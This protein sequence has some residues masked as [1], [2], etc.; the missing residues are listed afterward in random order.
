MLRVIFLIVTVL[1]RG[2]VVRVTLTLAAV[3]LAVAFL[4]DTPA[5]A[6][7]DLATRVAVG[8]FVIAVETGVFLTPVFPLAVVVVLAEL[9]LV[10][11][12]GFLAVGIA[13]DVK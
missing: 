3:F 1:V 8:F 10:L 5:F 11:V 6:A 13:A 2:F 4:G 9:D 7:T 12:A